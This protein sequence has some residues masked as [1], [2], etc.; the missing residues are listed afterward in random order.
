MSP[1][2]VLRLVTYLVVADGIAALLLAGLIGPLGAGFMGAAMLASW[3]FEDARARGALRSPLLWGLVGA[4]AVAVAAD[5]L[6][7][8]ASVLD[9]MV[10]LLL[11]VVLARLIMCRSLRDLRDAGFLSFFLLVAAATATFSMG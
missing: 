8:A 4:S 7:F 3:W 10:H 9:G 2:L 6:Y 1:L 5:L 11:F